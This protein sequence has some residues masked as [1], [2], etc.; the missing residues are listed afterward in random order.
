VIQYPFAIGSG[1]YLVLAPG[2]GANYRL[3]RR[4]A[5]R[6]E[7]EYQLWPNSP[8]IASQPA[9]EITPSG[10]HIGIAFKLFQ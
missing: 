1:N 9:H 6:G 4:W 3:S 5:L 2:A 8:N 7:Y 10:F